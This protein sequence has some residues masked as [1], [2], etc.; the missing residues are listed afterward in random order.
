M[1]RT[2]A[3]IGVPAPEAFLTIENELQAKLLS[4]NETFRFFEPFIAQ[5]RTVSQAAGDLG[6]TPDEML[7]RVRSFMDA[8]L[9]RIARHERRKGRPIKHY[10]SVADAFFIPFNVTYAEIEERGHAQFLPTTELLIR[11]LA[12]LRRDHEVSG[13]RIYRAGDGNVWRDGSPGPARDFDPA[14]RDI[15]VGDIVSDDIQLTVE[16]ARALQSELREVYD[17][18]QHRDEN[19]ARSGYLVIVGI[20]PLTETL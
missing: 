1:I 12:K 17:R 11:N 7:Y 10:R 2:D 8:G 5:E 13:Q 18:Y 9:L 3:E 19:R 20:S 4:R 15:P 6:C 14:S 16:E